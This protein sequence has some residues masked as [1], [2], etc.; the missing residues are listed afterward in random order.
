MPLFQLV[1]RSVCEEK[2][3]L[4]ISSGSSGIRVTVPEPSRSI[5]LDFC[6]MVYVRVGYIRFGGVSIC[7]L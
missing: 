6:F 7:C 4:T 1:F 5:F 3:L 2:G